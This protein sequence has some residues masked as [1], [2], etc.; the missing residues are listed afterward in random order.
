MDFKKA[1]A[2][3]MPEQTLFALPFAWLG[4]LFAG[5]QGLKTWLLVTFALAA[6]RTA[7]MAFNRAIDAK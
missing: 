6:A 5:G 3:I 2:L 4:L 1:A 7:G